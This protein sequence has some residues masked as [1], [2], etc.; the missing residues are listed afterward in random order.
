MERY[1][2]PWNFMALPAALG[3]RSRAAVWLLP[4]PYEGT[5]SYGAGTR[6]GPEAIVAASRQ[7][8]CYDREW[9]CEPVERYGIH[10]LPPLAL[11]HESAA[12]MADHVADTVRDLLTGAPAPRT[13]AVLGGEHSISGGVARGL[14]ATPRGRDLVAVQI[15]AHADLRDQYEGSSASHACA[16]RR[17]LE[18]CPVFQIGVRNLAAEEDVF[19][20][21]C[22][23]VHTVFAEDLHAGDAWLTDLETFTRGKNVYLTIDL[24]GLD[25][26]IMPAVGTPEP[27]GLTWRQTLR[28]VRA[29][30]RAAADVPVFDLVELAPV[31]G[32]LAPDFLAARLAYKIMSLIR[33]PRM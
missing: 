6:H 15:D 28:A 25:P 18:V 2:A 19:R 29:V 32:L 21:Q 8:E 1:Q 17:I 13:L 16:A 5:T 11:T 3:E 12:A 30:C 33:M 20:R 10:T 7:V 27:D 24:D 23:A 22:P 31:P 4:V 14:A 9:E 26:S